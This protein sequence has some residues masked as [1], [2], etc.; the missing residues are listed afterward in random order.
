MRF[1]PLEKLINLHNNYT[2]KFKIDTLQLLLLQRSDE[3]FLIEA[4]CPHREHPLD[5]AS[6]SDGVIQCALHQYQFAIRDGQLLQFTEER[7]R[8]LKTYQLTYL[9]NEVGVM[10]EDNRLQ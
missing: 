3:L 5:E 2:R 4:N 8:G 6:I 9:G 7:C 10:L 1:F